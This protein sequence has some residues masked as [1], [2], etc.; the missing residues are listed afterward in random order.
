MD[1]DVRQLTGL[2]VV[3]SGA[4]MVGLSYLAAYLLG[5]NAAHKEMGRRE[6]TEPGR[7]PDR[8]DRIESAVDSIAVEVERL[9]E[10]QRFMLNS[11][12]AEKAAQPAVLKPERRHATPV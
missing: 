10:G 8:L 7:Q 1:I 6:V 2:L 3:G 11:G 4:V 5:K 9:A 12:R